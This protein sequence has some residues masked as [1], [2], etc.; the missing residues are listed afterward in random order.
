L[1]RLH[2]YFSKIGKPTDEE[3]AILARRTEGLPYFH[4]TSVSRDDL[5]SKGFDVTKVSDADMV[6]L[7][8]KM[9][10]SYCND[11][12]WE[13]ME[14]IASERLGI[15]RDDKD[16]CP[17]CGSVMVCFDFELKKFVCL[18]CDGQWSD[19]YVLVEFPEDGTHFE[20]NGIG[21]PCFNSQDNGARYVPE[22][23]YISYFK[24]APSSGSL[25]RPVVWPESQ[26]YL[27]S[28]DDRCEVIMADEKALE[29]FGSSSVWVPV[30]LLNDRMEPAASRYETVTQEIR[31]RFAAEI[32][33]ADTNP[34]KWYEVF[35]TDGDGGTRTERR[36]ST[37]DEVVEHFGPIAD[38]FG[39]DNTS[40]DIWE[41]REEPR[42]I[43]LISA[44]RRNEETK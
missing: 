36:C 34:D 29:A 35:V 9:A 7:A 13:D 24:K 25:F 31:S 27:H 38:E 17:V 20:T 18:S 3:R 5:R 12:F 26:N 16:S 33:E 41:N 39:T 10:D 44:L 8:G 43:L 14:D 28:S 4:I 19:G 23:D 1:E 21:Y 15:P 6:R 11:S 40:V 32:A 22:Y 42:N 30:E 2:G 37:F